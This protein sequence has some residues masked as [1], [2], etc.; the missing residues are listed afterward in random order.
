MYFAENGKEALKEI[1]ENQQINLAIVDIKMPQMDGLELLTIM[2][3]INLKIDTI[4]ISAYGDM[5][6]I[7]K[8]MN[9]GVFDFLT[10]PFELEILEKAI[11]NNLRRKSAKKIGYLEK[12]YISKKQPTGEEKEYGPYIYFRKRDEDKKL[13]SIYLGR[14]EPWLQKLFELTEET[15]EL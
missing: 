6:K 15:P 10:K 8:A 5:E 1:L 7:R 3:Y 9:E 2:N 11:E 4:V 12:R 14:E 13:C